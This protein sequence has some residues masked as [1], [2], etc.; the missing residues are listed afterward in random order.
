MLGELPQKYISFGIL[1]PNP[2]CYAV[3]R[4]LSNTPKSVCIVAYKFYLRAATTSKRKL[5][6]KYLSINW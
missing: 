1:Q 3:S 4:S 5:G 6:V 2:S